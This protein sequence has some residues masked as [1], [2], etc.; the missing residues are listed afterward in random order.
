[1]KLLIYGDLHATLGREQLFSKPS[2]S[3]QSYRVQT[4]L[5]QLHEIFDKHEC[6]GIVDLGDT[7]D[8][9]N[10]LP[11][12]TLNVILEGLEVFS[13]SRSNNYKI[14]GNHDQVT[15]NASLHNGC[16]FNRVFNVVEKFL[17]QEMDDCVL[18]FY[19]HPASD[20]DAD[21]HVRSILADIRTKKKI[22][23]LGHLDVFGASMPS[24]RALAGIRPETLSGVNLALMGHIHKPQVVGDNIH[25]VGSP[26]QQ[27]Y[28][29]ANEDK[30]VAVLDTA[31]GSVE[32]VPITGMPKYRMV[33]FAAFKKLCKTDSEDRFRVNLAS[34]E[35]ADEFYS[36]PLSARAEPIYAYQS[37]A[38]TG[39]DEGSA[40]VMT[41]RE[42]M[43]KY[44]KTNP[45][46]VDIELVE[47]LAF[48]QDIAG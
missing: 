40:Q 13:K 18:I 17:V 8:D 37:A 44:V 47:L 25:F 7:L 35:E 39:G 45:P 1:M 19:S 43:E 3:L 15:K 21:K 33:S 48:G 41:M 30:R 16:V 10:S 20:V 6:E 23:F 26:F 5:G 29:E 22:F 34:P 4:F 31:T 42:A 27:D 24:G 14:I 9:R 2:E 11:I 28:G 12:Q 36:H 38:A 46:T 32:W